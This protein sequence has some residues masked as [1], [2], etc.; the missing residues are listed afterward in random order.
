MPEAKIIPRETTIDILWQ[1]YC[2]AAA[3]AE[4]T[5]KIED[6]ILAGKAWSRWLSNFCW[7]GPKP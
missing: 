3:Q 6:G 4:K 1:K 5:K 2:D 7:T